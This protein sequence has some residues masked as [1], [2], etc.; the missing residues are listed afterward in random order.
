MKFKKDRYYFAR[1]QSKHRKGT[2]QYS[3]RKGKSFPE[4]L[5]LKGCSESILSMKIQNTS[6]FQAKRHIFNRA[7]CFRF[8]HNISF[9]QLTLYY[10]EHLEFPCKNTPQNTFFKEKLPVTAFGMILKK[11]EIYC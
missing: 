11:R 4:Y 9:S 8:Q 5:I 10:P 1:K 2:P 7:Y 6:I 3:K